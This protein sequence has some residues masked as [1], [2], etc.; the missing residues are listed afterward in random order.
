MGDFFPQSF[1]VCVDVHVALQP[2]FK[3]AP[4][5]SSFIKRTQRKILQSEIMIVI[6]SPA[7]CKSDSCAALLECE[8]WRDKAKERDGRIC[9]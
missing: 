9:T 2:D 7:Y 3:K 6:S 1:P 4:L 5:M 8:K